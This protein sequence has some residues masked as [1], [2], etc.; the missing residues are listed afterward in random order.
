VHYAPPNPTI[1][2]WAIHS[3]K[4]YLAG[5]RTLPGSWHGVAA[6]GDR[7]T[8]SPTPLA[9]RTAVARRHRH[10]VPRPR[11]FAPTTALR[12]R[13]VV[14]WSEPG[15]PPPSAW[16]GSRHAASSPSQPVRHTGLHPT[17]SRLGFLTKFSQLLR[18]A[19]PERQR[20]ERQNSSAI[21]VHVRVLPPPPVPGS[22]ARYD[23]HRR[24]RG[25]IF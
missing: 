11:G 13:P 2:P 25:A 17:P 19:L 7:T 20:A 14:P 8:S 15:A 9:S 23:F 21:F 4:A 5:G 10:L 1:A 18:R 24:A 6:V 16:P 12:L 3:P 22:V